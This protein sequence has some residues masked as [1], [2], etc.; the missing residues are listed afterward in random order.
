MNPEIIKLLSEIND[1]IT[2]LRE[3]NKDIP[4]TIR[5]TM[6]KQLYYMQQA[7]DEITDKIALSPMHPADWN[8]IDYAN[9]I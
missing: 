7:H 8:N 9:N 3:L 1:R 6:A 4:D 2:R 5:V